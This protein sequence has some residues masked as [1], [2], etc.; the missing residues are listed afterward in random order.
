MNNTLDEK[1]KRYAELVV[2]VGCALKEGQEFYV[3]ADVSQVQLVRHVVRCAYESGAS[4]VHVQWA[5]EVVGRMNY[6]YKSVE[7]FKE[8]PEWRATLLNGMAKRGAAL[9]FISSEDPEAMSGIDQA[10]LMNWILASNKACRDWRDG[11]DYGRNVWCI[12]GAASPAWAKRV[13]PDLPEEEATAKLWD[14]ILHTARCDGEDPAADWAAHERSFHE[15]KAWLN[16]QNFEALHYTNSLGTDITVGMTD[17]HIW[18]GGGEITVDG[19]FF[20]PNMPTEEIF[21]TPHRLHTEGLVVSSIPLNHDGALVEGIRIRFEGGRAVEYS[22]TRGEDVLRQIIET[23]EGSHYL[24][25][26]ALVPKTSPIKQTGI[27]FLNTLF[28]ENA[29]CHFALGKG[30]PECYDGGRDLNKDELAAVGLNDSATHVDFMLGTD[31]LCIDGIK[32]DGTVVPVFR[33]G[34]WAF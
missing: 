14:A 3:S 20:F 31:D 34:T 16:S 24:G 6:D 21:T 5:D 1:L 15:R 10:K 26:C 4:N 12:I 33:E 2:K 19:T 11:M 27:L 8:F 17:K 7:S 28:D 22:A 23:D 25:E 32:P 30:F 13:F 9:L 29:S 18:E